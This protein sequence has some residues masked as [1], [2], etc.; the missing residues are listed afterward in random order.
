MRFWSMY[1]WKLHGQHSDITLQYN[2]NNDY[3]H[4]TLPHVQD[5]FDRHKCDC[6][7]GYYGDNCELDINE[8][9]APGPCENGATCVDLIAQ[10]ECRCPED[11]EVRNQFKFLCNSNLLLGNSL[12][13][14]C[15]S[16]A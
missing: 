9:S 12:G 13:Q 6:F 2:M 10:F 5:L 3:V 15:F 1:P 4:N 7:D 16:Q 14:W 11:Y 8:C